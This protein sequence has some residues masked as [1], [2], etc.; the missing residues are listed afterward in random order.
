MATASNK[1]LRKTAKETR[2]TLVSARLQQARRILIE[3]L[4]ESD[5]K[6][7][8]MI[9]S[10]RL[11]KAKDILIYSVREMRKK[12]RQDDNQIDPVNTQPAA[13]PVPAASP[14]LDTEILSEVEAQEG[15]LVFGGRVATAQQRSEI[16]SI[17]TK[18]T[19]L[20]TDS[21]CTPWLQRVEDVDIFRY[22]LWH[23]DESLAWEK[24]QATAK[25]REEEGIDGVLAE[26]LDDV[27]EAGKEEML[28]LPPDKLGRPVLLYRSAL[29][30]PGQ[31]D[32]QR[33][34]RY[35]I[36]QTERARLQYGL[37]TEVQSIVIV[38]R[39]GS[40][41]KNQDPALLKVLL[42]VIVEHYPEVVGYVYVAP[43]SLVFNV[44][45]KLLQV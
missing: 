15:L 40:G 45:W 42:P 4:K 18:I 13:V 21:K 27:F 44:I 33:F 31:I 3:A 9:G 23:K 41:L 19:A 1:L 32:P 10:R 20:A 8:K 22:L 37:G 7:V 2:T 26:N 5:S 12:R 25:W 24:L 29:H 39:I 43:I 11:A 14:I 30:K 36:Q 6:D 35:V 38:D 28:Y 34:T 16:A 17:R